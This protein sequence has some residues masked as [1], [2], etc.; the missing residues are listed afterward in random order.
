[1]EDFDHDFSTYKDWDLSHLALDERGLAVFDRSD[2]YNLIAEL[3]A[4]LAVKSNPYQ[5][6]W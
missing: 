1:M 4:R 5:G 6:G 2:L 3:G